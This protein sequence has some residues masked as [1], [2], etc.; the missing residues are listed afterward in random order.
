MIDHEF[1]G[2]EYPPH[3]YEIGRE[4]MREYARAA[5]DVKP[6]HVDEAAG[7]A[8][9]Y[10]DIIATPSFAAVYDMLGAVDL[11][12]DPEMEINFAMLVHGEQEFEWHG[13]AKPG[14]VMTVT[15]RVADIY[16]KGDLDFVVYEA[17]AVNQDEELVC[18]GRA[19]FV[20]RGG[21]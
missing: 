10:G 9:K 16:E 13:V 7:R 8:S 6:I 11:F 3:K 2:K 21:G 19:T 12:F 4:K 20:I 18:V 15:G 1:I 17:R 14:D 5:G